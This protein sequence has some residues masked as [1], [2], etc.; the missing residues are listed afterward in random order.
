MKP[1]PMTT[2]FGPC[3]SRARSAIASS[4]DRSVKTP[5]RSG[6]IGRRRATEPVAMMRPSN[7]TDSPSSSAIV[8]AARSRAVARP[9]GASRGR[10]P[11]RPACAVRRRRVR[12]CPRADPS[13]AAAGRTGGAAR[14]RSQRCDCRSP[15]G[16]TSRPRAD[17][18]ATCRRLRWFAGETPSSCGA[19]DDSRG[20]VT[21]GRVPDVH[22]ILMRLRCEFRRPR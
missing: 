9:R 19:S 3:S 18:R 5:S 7:A 1:A 8:R 11:R 17:P 6:C 21:S 13:T 22:V 2:T 15:R 14:P 12:S 4:S 16:A 10:G 20:C